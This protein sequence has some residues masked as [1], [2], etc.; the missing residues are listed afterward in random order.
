[1]LSRS[2]TMREK[3]LLVVLAFLLLFLAYYQFVL[4]GTEEAIKA[5]DTSEL[6]NTL[7]Y[8]EARALT[9]ERMLKAMG[10]A[11]ETDNKQIP[12]YDNLKGEL[13]AF[14][15][16]LAS[17]DEYT[18]EFKDPVF[19]GEIVRRNLQVTYW[20]S[21]YARTKDVLDKLSDC[22][23]RCIIKEVSIMTTN[24]KSNGVMHENSPKAIVVSLS[25][26]F[27]EHNEGANIQ[28]ENDR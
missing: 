12:D 17:T 9:K 4:R 10:G 7:I 6:E 28:T 14:E 26:T 23:Y 16:I 1:M 27:F 15:D 20:A 3:V 13:R 5:Y 19:E 21:N 11:M 2:F 25:V 22:E 8:E 18:V 24:D